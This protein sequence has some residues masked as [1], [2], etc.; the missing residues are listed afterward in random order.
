[1]WHDGAKPDDELVFVSELGPPWYAITGADG[2]RAL[3]PLGGGALSQGP[4]PRHLG[5][6]RRGRAGRPERVL[7]ADGK[8]RH[9]RSYA[10]S[11]LALPR[12]AA[13]SSASTDGVSSHGR[14][15]PQRSTDAAGR[16][17]TPVRIPGRL[18]SRRRRRRRKPL[19][20]LQRAVPA[21]PC[22]ARIG[23]ARSRKMSE[24]ELQTTELQLLD[25]YWRAAN[26]L[27]VGQVYLLDNPLLREPLAPEHVKPRL[28]GHFGTTPG[29]NLVYAHLNRAIRATRPER[30]LRHGPRP[31]RAR[32]RREHLP[33][34]D[35]LR[36]IP[37]DHRGRG[38]HAP[39]LST[40]LVSRRDPE[41]RGAGDA[42]VDS[43][44]RRAWLFT[45]TR[46]RR[47]VRQPRSDRRL[48]RRRRRG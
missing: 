44:G 8:I 31:R 46:L 14:P 45:L 1:M 20:S 9:E 21:G 25:A 5:A 28:L 11:T 15:P 24:A 22:Q 4:G 7:A 3:G 10:L 36:A 13:R 35:V 29:L 41:P 48:R 43:R 18:R 30:S 2:Q 47:R 16:S 42:G 6:G 38:G 12:S 27:S 40:V 19:R 33:R 17:G 39:A 23:S 37:G 32:P 34:G 26:Y